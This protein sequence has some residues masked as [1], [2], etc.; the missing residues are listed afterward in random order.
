[1]ADLPDEEQLAAYAEALA[2]GVEAALPA[3]VVQNVTRVADAWR[4]G[5]GAELATEARAAGGAAA[6]EVGPRLRALVRADVDA[7]ASGP[8]AVVREAVVFPTAVLA[9]AGVG[10]VARDPFAER[11]FPADVYDLAPASFAD[12][13]AALH[14]PGLVWGAAKA[15]VVLSR[16][17]GRSSGG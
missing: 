17:R 4:P 2:D 6:A 15:H 7:Q 13:D 3:W 1:M 12:V 10:P 9:A 14:E 11:A 16:R 8:L 5:L